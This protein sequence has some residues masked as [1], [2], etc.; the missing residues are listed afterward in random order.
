MS[1]MPRR[2]PFDD[3]YLLVQTQWE[4]YSSHYDLIGG[5]GDVLHR[6][7]TLVDHTTTSSWDAWA[8]GASDPMASPT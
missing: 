1:Y 4:L 2:V 3:P 5:C 6:T 8:P 7:L